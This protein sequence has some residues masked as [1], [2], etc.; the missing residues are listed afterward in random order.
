METQTST[1]ANGEVV[2]VVM[3]PTGSG[4]TTF[5]NLA[6]GSHLRVGSGLES[7]TSDIQTSQSFVVDGR[8]IRLVDTPG[9]D[10]TTKSDTEVLKLIAAFLTTTYEVGSLLAGVIYIHRIS[11]FRMG[12]VSTRNFAM[13]RQL[14]GD[15]TLKNMIVLTNM[16][17]E[18]SLAVGEAREAELIS[19]KRFFKPVLDRKAKLL[20]HNNT[21]ESAHAILRSIAS[22][23]P[24]ALRIQREI[25]DEGKG[26]SQ[27]AAGMEVDKELRAQERRHSEEMKNVKKEMEAA[28]KIRDEETRK[29]M[30]AS[31]KEL[32]DE[33][34]RVQMES[35]KL[36]DGFRVEKE[37]MTH[38]MDEVVKDAKRAAAA[39]NTQMQDLRDRLADQSNAAQERA[40]IMK[41]LLELQSRPPVVVH[42]GPCVIQ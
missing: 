5:I 13:F 9:F 14:C 28:M 6:S 37:R 12:G 15:D 27:T 19:N 31:Y 11:D 21:L 29:E 23:R 39:H 2:I 18:V 26:V 32:Q 33:M 30:E 24:M 25:V 17:G 3:G 41:Q 22:N 34:A 40:D 42:S 8:Y 38:L 1:P 20:R 35:Q 7:C 4:K 10:D 36:R 16:W